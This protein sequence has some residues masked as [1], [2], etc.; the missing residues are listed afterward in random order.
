MGYHTGVV[1]A[2]NLFSTII[3][4][5]TQTQPEGSAPYWKS[6]SSLPTDA[7]YTSTGSTGSERIVVTLKEGIIGNNIVVGYAKDYTPGAV[8]T[9][10]TFVNLQE[11]AVN[12][13]SAVQNEETAVTYHLSVTADRIIIHLQGDKLITQ[14]QNPLVFLGIPVR[15]D[16]SDK[17]CVV[18]LASENGVGTANT[19][20][21][22]EDSIGTVHRAYQWKYV[23]STANPSWGG[24]YF[25]ETLHFSYGAEG[26]R[27]ELD[28]IFGTH[29]GALIDGD[30]IDVNGN[31]YL[32]IIRRTNGVN[33]FPRTALLMRMA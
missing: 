12:Y 7:V 26:L 20:Q 1:T 33:N 5:I 14:W 15:Y 23:E 3:A 29:E 9:A 8:N 19:C 24:K 2:G 21:V 27:G 6:E 31:T 13:Y 32:V 4:K 10:G 28:G 30:Q 18:K 22:L 16:T 11:Q 17:L 25:V